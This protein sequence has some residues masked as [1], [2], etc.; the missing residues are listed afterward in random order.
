MTATDLGFVHV[1]RPGRGRDA[2]T[3]LLLHS[4][5]ADE[6]SLLPLATRLAKGTNVLSPRGKVLENGM[7]RFFRRI[8]VGVFDEEDLIA[9]THELADFVA[10][11][12]SVYSF[13]ATRV[14]AVGFSNGANIAAST[15]LLRPQVYAGAVLFKAQVPLEPER[16][17]QL[18]GKP[19]FVA[20]G[21]RDELIDAR[22]TERLIEIL[23][24]GGAEVAIHWQPG[25]HQL[26]LEEIEAACAWMSQLPLMRD[27]T[28]NPD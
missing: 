11:A 10:N 18:D 14:I 13:D 5:G 8:A 12:S 2:P 17:P 1:Y 4:T 25:G 7:P 23:A 22:D 9:R 27:Y 21:R 15:L 16:P 26:T 20:A 6:N 24:S 19:V 28:A 3:L